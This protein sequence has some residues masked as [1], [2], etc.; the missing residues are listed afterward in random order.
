MSNWQSLRAQAQDDETLYH[1]ILD[2][3]ERGDS[4]RDAARCLNMTRGSLRAVIRKL[5][6]RLASAETVVPVLPAQHN[7]K[8]VSTLVGRDGKSKLQWV[9]TGR[10]EA[11]DPLRFQ[12]I[13]KAL[14]NLTPRIPIARR[15]GAERELNSDLC[16]VY[17]FGDPHVGMLAYDRET[18]D[19]NWDLYIAEWTMIEAMQR[20]M[21]R[22]PEAERA[23][24]I[25]LG[26]FFHAQDDKQATPR[27]GHKVDVDSRFVRVA[28]V[29]CRIVERLVSCLEYEHG[30]TDLFNV[31]GNHDPD[32]GMW[33]N[34]WAKARFKNSPR[35]TVHDNANPYT[36]HEF[37]RN[38]LGLA[39]GHG[40]KIER[41]P[42]VMANDARAAWGNAKHAR[43][44]T[45]HHHCYQAF[46]ASGCL[47][48]KYP[49]LA[50]RD[51]HTAEGG[52]RSERALYCVTLHR[53]FGEVARGKITA[54]E[55]EFH[56]KIAA[57]RKAA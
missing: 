32:A 38:L 33:L 28:E 13:E 5:R 57:P 31:R 50:P 42:G 6:R 47:V 54:D 16:N 29:G 49:T 41:L 19:A 44:I 21:A 7:L 14:E 10:S 12:A 20:L 43:W 53:Q 18:G 35:V 22:V 48:E 51:Y 52:W 40:C 27:S 30:R 1:A 39:H 23:I 15:A 25:N 4:E 26:D 24:L 34:L 11:L 56:R 45:G 37:G 46:E 36:F 55:L 9:K 8:G 2:H 17:I 3:L